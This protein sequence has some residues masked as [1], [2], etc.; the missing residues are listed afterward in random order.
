MGGSV[1]ADIGQHTSATVGK[2]HE[3]INSLVVRLQ[4]ER[5]A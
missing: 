1:A 3:Q 5:R 2:W 4:A